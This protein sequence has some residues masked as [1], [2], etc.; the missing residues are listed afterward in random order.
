M[1]DKKHA[2]PLLER[3]FLFPGYFG[4]DRKQM[5]AGYSVEAVE[6][7]T[8]TTRTDTQHTATLLREVS[9]GQKRRVWPVSK[10]GVTL[11]TEQEERKGNKNN[12]MLGKRIGIRMGTFDDLTGNPNAPSEH[13]SQ[14]VASRQVGRAPAGQQGSG[15]QD[16]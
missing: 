1:A 10:F 4:L 7:V 15:L 2:S 12:K 8:K 16:L 9:A 6:V 13:G 14:R 11:A 5:P 3:L